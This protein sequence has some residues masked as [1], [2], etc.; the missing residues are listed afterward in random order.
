MEGFRGWSACAQVCGD[1]GYRCA[2]SHCSAVLLG[3]AVPRRR[4]RPS[5]RLPTRRRAVDSDTARA[6]DVLHAATNLG[7]EAVMDII[8][9]VGRILFA[10]LFVTS[11]VAHFTQ[12]QSMAGYAASK[13]V[14]APMAAVLGGGVLLLAGS[15]SVLLGVWADLGALLLVVFH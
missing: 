8:V 15:L 14:P 12:R 2:E 1:T 4:H 3:L 9:L 7:W 6:Q 13:G 10:Y 5:A 11:G